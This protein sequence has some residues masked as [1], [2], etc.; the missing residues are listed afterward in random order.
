[1]KPQQLSKALVIKAHIHSLP[2]AE[3]R[4]FA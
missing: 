4:L 3:N 2:R 1:M